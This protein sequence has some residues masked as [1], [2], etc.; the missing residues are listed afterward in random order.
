MTASVT[1]PNSI[2]EDMTLSGNRGVWVQETKR[3]RRHTSKKWRY[4]GKRRVQVLKKLDESQV[5][6]IIQQKQKGNKN[7]I[8]ADTMQVSIRW[9]QK[10][11]ARYKDI[12]D[13]TYPLP[14]GRP[15]NGLTGRR[16]HSTVLTAAIM[17]SGAR[18]L[19]NIMQQNTGIHIPHNTA[20][21]ILVENDLAFEET[22][23]KQQRKY[24]RYEREHSNSMWHTDYKQL[25]DGRWFLAYQDD[26][27]RF[28]TGYGVFENMTAENAIKVLEQTIKNHGKPASILTD[29]G[30]QFYA[31]AAELKKK[32]QSKYEE[33]L[34]KLDIKH[35]LARVRHPQTN[36]KLE[37]FHG[38]LQRK[39]HTFADVAGPPGTGA[40]IGAGKIET[41]PVARFVKWY[42]DRPHESLDWDHLETPSQAFVRKKAPNDVALQEDA[43]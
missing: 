15:T 19:E 12:P 20:H 16:E 4:I 29:H 38:E 14:M 28:I 10:L 8:I 25:D 21:K 35:I 32:G 34:V 42:N 33:K 17:R 43:A 23:K 2:L 27:S 40:P 41:D 1:S 30:S 24:L 9:V 11:W 22:K 6:W 3:P 26:A 5:K 7:R 31:N 36:G 39:L 18:L 37:R 13:I